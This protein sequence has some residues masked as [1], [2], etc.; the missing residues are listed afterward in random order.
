MRSLLFLLCV[1]C[2]LPP[3]PWM[4]LAMPRASPLL[5]PS[6]LPLTLI[7]GAAEWQP[8]ATQS[9]LTR[10]DG[11]AVD[12]LERRFGYRA[13]GA[14]RVF[15]ATQW[16]RHHA[17]ACVNCEYIQP[18]LLAPFRLTPSRRFRLSLAATSSF[19]LQLSQSPPPSPTKAG[20]EAGREGNA[21]G[22]ALR[23]D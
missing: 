14:R 23:R 13:L 15:L 4:L 19:T 18:Y 2:R 3:A 11:D 22:L 16:Y 20:R 12:I 7:T 17:P 8:D 10:D 9:L 1:A 21:A 5:A 6:P